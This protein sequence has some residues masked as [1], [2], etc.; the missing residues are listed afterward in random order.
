MTPCKPTFPC[1]KKILTIS[2]AGF[3]AISQGCSERD[4][5]PEQPQSKPNILI[6]LP[7]DMG[8]SD[9][10]YHGSDIKTP[11]LDQLARTGI[12]LNQHYVMPTCTPTR[13]CLMTGLYASRYGV[14]GPHYGEVIYSGDPTLAT[15]LGDHGYHT[16]IAGKWHMGSP[17]Y[18]PLKYG[19][20][21]SYGYFDGQIDPYT[22]EYKPDI[23]IPDRRT[24]SWHRNDT[25]IDESGTHVTDL[26]TAEAIRVIEEKR[27]QPF[28][29][30]VAHHV[31]HFP[32][33]EPDEWLSLYDDYLMHP[34]R[35]LF[36]ASITHMDDGIGKIVDALE[37]TGQRENTIIIFFSDNGGQMY[38]G[39]DRRDREYHGRFVDKPHCVLGNNF[40]LRGWKAELYEG[41]I[42]VPAFV[43][44][45]KK[46]DPG[47]IDY[48]VHVTDW[49]PTISEITGIERDLL[50][51]DLDGQ[52]IWP[53]LTGEQPFQQTRQP[54]Y[55]KTE[56]AYAVRDAEWKL[57]KHRTSKEFELYNLEH[58]F[59]E[60]RD[61]SGIYPEKAEKLMTILE[62]FKAGDEMSKRH[63]G[64]M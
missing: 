62:T 49:L 43:S 42:R 3:M 52:T 18:T 51:P 38:W 28:F 14:V 12:R 31:P 9:I 19:F 48:P 54:M 60:I 58:D 7:D 26:I 34:A 11:N 50:R 63:S 56:W 10:G 33:D 29:L 13:V 6:I 57:I 46:L 53:I 8:W 39:A 36:A 41:G 16:A 17:P 61:L 2:V 20:H 47:I 35:R 37:R 24:R 64:P 32:L 55:W 27:D 5:V 25:F 45:P 30:Y 59:R 40:P 22:H 21:T 15:L 4:K 1:A 44:W 23:A